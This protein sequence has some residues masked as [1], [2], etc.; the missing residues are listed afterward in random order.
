MGG[1]GDPLETIGGDAGG[2]GLS[3]GAGVC[4]G[5]GAGLPSVGE[6]GRRGNPFRE[7][8]KV[9]YPRSGGPARFRGLGGGYL[10]PRC[11][12]ADRKT[13]GVGGAVKREPQTCSRG[14]GGSGGVLL[15][16]RRRV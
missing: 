1:G 3:V 15:C 2:G 8:E 4:G 9:L 10:E 5:V 11:G 12:W 14:S 7:D 16:P 13:E 6:G